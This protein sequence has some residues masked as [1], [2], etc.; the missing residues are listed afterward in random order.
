MKNQSMD[1]NSYKN[2]RFDII[3]LAGQSNAYGFGIG[4]V[5]SEFVENE[6][7]F[8][9]SDNLDIHF[10]KDENGL[11]YLAIPEWQSNSIIRAKE[12]E[13]ENGKIGNLSLSFADKYINDGMLDEGRKILIVNA[14]VG[15]TGFMKK[16]WG[17]DAV[18]YRRLV[19][20]TK[21]ALRLNHE[22]RVVAVLWH[23]GEHDAFE[24][25]TMDKDTRC[26]FYYHSLLSMF[27]NYI[28]TFDLQGIP[29]I[30]GSFCDEWYSKNKDN[31]DAVLKALEKVLFTFGSTVV[32]SKGL[33]S[34]NEK[35]GN[36]DDI[37][38]CREALY[39]LGERYFAEY[40]RTLDGKLTFK[41]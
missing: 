23:Q 15:G 40:K 7:I 27:Y 18:L 19:E 34:N 8:F 33:M 11:D 14:A 17:V 6:S 29:I 21:I 39:L 37:H 5:E 28:D 22:N 35:N 25:P 9:L 36:G 2:D 4:P 30:A 3:V 38:F 16:H 12:K 13:A 10:E 31:C 1:I 26:D 24:S 20:L 41:V 32:S